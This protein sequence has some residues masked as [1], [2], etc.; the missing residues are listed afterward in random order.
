MPQYDN[1]SMAKILAFLAQ[2][3]AM[4]LH[5]P[6]E[7]HEI[8]KLPRGWVVNVGATIVGQPFVEWVQK[9]IAERN[10]AMAKER[11]LLI[12]MNPQLAAAF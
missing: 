11:N 5:M 8:N 7:H 9:R 4:H 10:V 3:E 6:A 1:L 12:R 2:Y